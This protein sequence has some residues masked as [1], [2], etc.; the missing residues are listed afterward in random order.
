M[1]RGA[2]MSVSPLFIGVIIS[3][4]FIGVEYGGS[5]AFLF[6]AKSEENSLVLLLR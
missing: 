6:N 4:L 3:A 5:R 1:R 2:H